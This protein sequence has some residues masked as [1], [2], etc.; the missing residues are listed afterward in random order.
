MA[1]PSFD[2]PRRSVEP[3]SAEA[4]IARHT[5]LAEPSADSYLLPVEGDFMSPCLRAGDTVLVDP[6]DDRLAD[7]IVVFEFE[8]GVP[9][10]ARVQ[11]IPEGAR[12]DGEPVRSGVRIFGD[13]PYYD[14]QIID[15]QR[16]RLAL[17]GR[18]R[19]LVKR[20]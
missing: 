13:N 7:G 11:L 15:T 17:M 10:I 14:A 5:S 19:A 12:M 8:P 20:V 6:A 18:V 3:L 4:L 2:N 1:T 16:A 9:M